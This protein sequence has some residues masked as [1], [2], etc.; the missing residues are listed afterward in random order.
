M[1]LKLIER[2][3]IP[4]FVAAWTM[5]VRICSRISILSGLLSVQ[6]RF[7]LPARRIAQGD[8]IHQR[9]RQIFYL[10]FRTDCFRLKRPAAG[11]ASHPLEIAD[12]HGTQ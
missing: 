5:I 12:F 1:P 7:G 2:G 9:H 11:W 10:I 8:L 3:S 4:C 6:S